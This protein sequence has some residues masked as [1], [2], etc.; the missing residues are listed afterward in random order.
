MG[1]SYLAWSSYFCLLFEKRER[2]KLL[3]FERY[4]FK[5]DKV[6]ERQFLMGARGQNPCHKNHATS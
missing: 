3:F 1:L 5:M 4:A 6:K 2:Q